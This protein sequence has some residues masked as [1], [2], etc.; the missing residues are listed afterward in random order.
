MC[1][2]LETVSDSERDLKRNPWL[3]LDTIE[4]KINLKVNNK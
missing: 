3:I 4:E 1:S 2:R